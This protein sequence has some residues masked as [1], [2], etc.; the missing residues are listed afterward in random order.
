MRIITLCLVLLVIS[1]CYTRLSAQDYKVAIGVRFSTSPPTLSNSFSVKYFMDSVNALEGLISFG[2]RFGLGGLYERHQLIGG[3][4]AFT[5][6]W[7]VGGY[8]GFQDN[9]TYLGPTGAIGLDY[10][11]SNA[12]INLSLDWKPELDILPSINFVPDAFG[13]TARFTFGK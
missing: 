9:N 3:T 8:V 10:K 2:T 4:P 12:P 11:F 5:W 7:G 6:F 13:L 1:G